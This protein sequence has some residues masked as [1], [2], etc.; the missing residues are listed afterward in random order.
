MTPS[1]LE[2]DIAHLV[3]LLDQLTPESAP[4]WG[5]MNAQQMVE[6]LT[7]SLKMSSGKREFNSEIPDDRISK[8]HEFL[9]S[10]KPMERNIDVPF[11][12]KNATLVNEELALAIDAFLLEWIDFEEHF[13]ERPNQTESHPYYGP[14]TYHQ[15]LR[16]HSKHLT[17]HFEQ[18]GL[19]NHTPQKING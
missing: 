10:D 18:F 16:L 17:H 19:I 3:S 1:F 11:A 9:A 2:P 14:L 13:A 6:H 5:T 12:P 15:W 8:M 7:E 4:K